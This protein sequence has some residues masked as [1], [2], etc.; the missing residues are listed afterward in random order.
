MRR[1]VSVSDIAAF[2]A[3]DMLYNQ[4]RFIEAKQNE[5]EFACQGF[6]KCCQIGLRLHMFECANIAYNIR[7][8]YYFVLEDNGKDTADSFIETIVDDLR[9]RMFDDS[10]EPGGETDEMCAFYDNGCTI[11]KYRP[12]VC[13]SF[14]T[15]SPVDDYCKRM[16]KEDGGID[17]FS[18]KAV[19]D[20][21]KGFQDLIGKY[22]DSK[23][24]DKNYDMVV[25]MPLG[26]LAFLL[27]DEEL[28]QLSFSADEKFWSGNIGWF[29]YRTY[30]TKKYGYDD[31]Y[32]EQIAS[33]AGMD[34]IYTD[35]EG[36]DVSSEGRGVDSVVTVD[37]RKDQDID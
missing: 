27:P 26:V 19:E 7:Q 8:Q 21:V 35:V 2:G 32:L 17:F 6:G 5:T 20:V 11:Y 28:H 37:I 9:E 25:Y 15:I 24:P 4:L 3:L 10:W 14:G 30:F 22:A 18:G 31:S 34:V 1:V 23:P 29:N 33:D 16:R 13:R 12:M 36:L